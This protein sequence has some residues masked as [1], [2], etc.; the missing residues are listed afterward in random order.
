MKNYF[1]FFF[2]F[3]LFRWLLHSSNSYIEFL[4]DTRSIIALT[5][6]RRSTGTTKNS[7]RLG[8]ICRTKSIHSSQS[9]FL[10]LPSAF[11]VPFSFS[12]LLFCS[13]PHECVCVFPFAYFVSRVYA[14]KNTK[15]YNHTKLSTHRYIEHESKRNR[16]TENPTE[17]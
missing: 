5:F 12:R 17:K 6:V 13:F 10:F 4:I 14:T 3:Q 1:D 2:T 15:I 7:C 9:F 11:L 16:A 8:I